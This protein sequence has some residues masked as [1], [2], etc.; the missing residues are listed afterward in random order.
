MG[1]DFI[2]QRHQSDCWSD[3]LPVSAHVDTQTSTDKQVILSR[4]WYNVSRLRPGTATMTHCRVG[5]T[6]AVIFYSM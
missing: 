4:Y 5:A 2:F 1:S 3:E 6:V